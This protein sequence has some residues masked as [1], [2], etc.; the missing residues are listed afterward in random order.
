MY[1]EGHVGININIKSLKVLAFYVGLLMIEAVSFEIVISV[2]A[3]EKKSNLWDVALVQL[4]PV[5]E[6]RQ[7]VKAMVHAERVVAIN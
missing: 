2:K 4:P 7:A 6:P 5:P 3:I 1:C